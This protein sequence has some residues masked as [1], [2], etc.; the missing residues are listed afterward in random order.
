M[1]LVAFTTPLMRLASTAAGLGAGPG[2]QTWLLAQ[3]LRIV[4]MLGTRI[5]ERL[6]ENIGAVAVELWPADL[7]DIESA[8]SKSMVQGAQYSESSERMIAHGATSPVRVD[9]RTR[10]DL[11]LLMRL[12]VTGGEDLTILTVLTRTD[13]LLIR[14]IHQALQR[15]AQPCKSRISRR[16]PLLR[17]AACYTVLRSR[18]YQSGIS[19]L[20]IRY[21]LV[22]HLLNFVTTHLIATVLLLGCAN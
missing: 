14:V 16:F 19:L 11:R 15:F 12:R 17:V 7:H 9:E 6:D 22:P 20:L 1:V 5:L 18:W 8:T 10:A 13:N 3:K 2:A 21:T 4:P